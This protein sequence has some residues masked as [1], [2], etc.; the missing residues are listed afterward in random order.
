MVE[1]LEICSSYALKQNPGIGI[2]ELAQ[3]YN[4]PL[5]TYVN[6]NTQTIR[7]SPSD[8]PPSLF[9]TLQPISQTRKHTLKRGFSL[10]IGGSAGEG[11]QVAAEILAKA[12]LSCGLNVTKK[13]V[14]PV[15][16][17]IG[18]SVAEMILSIGPIHFTDN[19]KIEGA[20]MT[21]QDGMDYFSQRIKKMNEGLVV[22]D[23]RLDCPNRRVRQVS[24]DF[25]QKGKEKQAM[26]YGML[27]FLQQSG[28][29]PTGAFIDAI[30]NHPVGRKMDITEFQKEADALLRMNVPVPAESNRVS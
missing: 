28:I 1:F 3:K 17:G 16:V 19:Q 5:Q 9:D 30:R 22:T 15:T 21:S 4:I 18:F 13:G 29:F 23:S 8:T 14:Y 7:L 24:G 11:I 25:R 20:I 12:A 2:R 26:L 27:T 6:P 10:I